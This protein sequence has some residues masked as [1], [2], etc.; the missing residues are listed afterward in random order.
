MVHILFADTSHPK[1]YGFDDLAAQAMGGTESSLLRTAKI[2]SSHNHQVTVF[3]QQRKA[4][5]QQTKSS[6][7]TAPISH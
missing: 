5:E 4:S 2:L 6:Q 1:P 7:S 3:Q